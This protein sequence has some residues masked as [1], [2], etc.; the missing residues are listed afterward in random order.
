MFGLAANLIGSVFGGSKGAN[1]SPFDAM[2][3]IMSNDSKKTAEHQM[4]NALEQNAFNR[5]MDTARTEAAMAKDAA[6]FS[7]DVAAAGREVTSAIQI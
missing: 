1:S 4:N 5:H 6:Q 7:K 3:D 2:T